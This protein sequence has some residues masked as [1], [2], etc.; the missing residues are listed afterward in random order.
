MD[1][2]ASPKR[3]TDQ[4]LGKGQAEVHRISPGVYNHHHH[5]QPGGTPQMYTKIFGLDN[6]N[7]VPGPKL[8]TRGYTGGHKN[9]TFTFRCCPL[10]R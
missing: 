2:A 4:K 10:R 5:Q 3:I 8:A 6:G 1:R 7:E 9:T